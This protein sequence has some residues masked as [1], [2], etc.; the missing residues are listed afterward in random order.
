MKK[1]ILLLLLLWFL[2]MLIFSYCGKKE[3][4]GVVTLRYMRW[5]N[6]EEI[7]STKELLDFF[8]EKNPDIKVKFYSEAWSPYWD[9]L[10]TQLAGGVGPDVFMN[11]ANFC[12]DFIQKEVILNLYPFL[13]KD[14]EFNKKDFFNIPFELYKYKGAL[15]AIP[16]DINVIILYYNKDLFDREGIPYPTDNWTWNDLLKT[17]KKLTRD[18]NNDGILDQWGFSFSIIGGYEVCWGNL[19]YQNNV[20]VLNKER[21]KCLLNSPAALE[22]FQFLYDLEHKHKVVPSTAQY[23]SLGGYDIF[24]TAKIAMRIDGSWRMK[25]YSKAPFKWDIAMLPRN[26]RRACI[27]NGIA[28][29]INASTRYPA[30][31]WRLVKFLSDKESQIAVA[32]SGTALPIRKSIAYSKYFLDGVPG[33]KIACLKSIKYGYNYETTSRTMEWWK[34]LDDEL[35]LAFLKKKLLKQALDDGVVRVNKILDEINQTE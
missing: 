17:A 23:E 16:R 14:K 28:H 35:Q 9:K 20:R 21:T 12:S 6:E 5:A 15:Y 31:A 18:S 32:E 8:M 7:K 27:A 25:E 13:E 19:L 1:M 11:H 3:K 22:V 29:S 2:C 30:S 34:H 24:L 10:Q 26:K 4:E 33:N